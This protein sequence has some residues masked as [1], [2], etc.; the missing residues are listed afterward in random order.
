[1]LEGSVLRL[2]KHGDILNPMALQCLV[3]II[4]VSSRADLADSVAVTGPSS[5]S[6]YWYNPEG[7]TRRRRSD[8]G[9][10]TICSKF[11]SWYVQNQQRAVLLLA[12]RALSSSRW[13][14]FLFWPSFHKGPW[15]TLIFII[16]FLVGCCGTPTTIFRKHD[17]LNVHNLDKRTFQNFSSAYRATL[18]CPSPKSL[19]ILA[20]T[21]LSLS[22]TS[23][24]AVH[25]CDIFITDV[26]FQKEIYSGPGCC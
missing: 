3:V 4:R 20:Y 21:L 15:K 23:Y 11:N 9:G 17:K 6:N 16:H 5:F 10:D 7:R 19:C 2:Y 13:I 1:M 8:L 26:S 24:E 18:W 25:E 12:L 14:I 22:K